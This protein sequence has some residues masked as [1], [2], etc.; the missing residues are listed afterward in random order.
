[1]ECMKDLNCDGAVVVTTPQQVSL[2]DVRK[3]LTFC[4]KTDIKILGII[5]NMRYTS[6]QAKSMFSFEVLTI[7]KLL[8]D[9]CVLNVW[10]VQIFSRR[11]VEIHWQL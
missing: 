2:E 9:S 5:E 10:T 3:E 4:I 11:V 8:A 6:N 7:W 1:M